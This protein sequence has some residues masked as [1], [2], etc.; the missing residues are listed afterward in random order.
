MRMKKLYLTVLTLL[1]SISSFSQVIVNEGFEAGNTDGLPPTGW[2]CDAGGWKCGFQEQDHNRIPHSGD[3]YA[4]CSYRMYKWMFKEI[5]V[6]ANSQYRVSFWHVTNGVGSFQFEVKVGN[7]PDS[8]HMTQQVFPLTQINNT[9]YQYESCTFT[10]TSAGT[11]YVGFHSC[12]DFNP[13]YLVIDDIQIEQTSEYNFAVTPLTADTSVYFGEYGHFRFNIENTGTET[14]TVTF[15]NIS[16]DY[17]NVTFTQNGNTVTNLNIPLNTTLEVVA[18]AQLPMN[19]TPNQDVTLSFDVASAHNTHSESMLFDGTAL[20]PIDEFPLMEGFDGTTFPPFGWQ[21]V[22]LVGDEVYERFTNGEWPMCQPHNGSAAMARYYSYLSQVGD[23]AILVSPK[24]QLSA[25]DNIVRFWIFR[26]YNSWQKSDKI[27]VYYSPTN[28]L[29][30]AT[31]LGTVH[32]HTE[33]EPVVPN[34]D[35]W[36]EYS[37]SFGSPEGYGFVIFEAVSDR[38]WN[39][40]I[41]DIFVNSTTVDNDPPT[42]I[43]VAGTQ[44]W[45]DTDMEITVRIYDESNVPDEMEATY[46]IDGQLNNVTFHK[47]A[48][49]NYDFV[50]TIPARENHTSGYIVFHLED[51]LGHAADSDPY[52]IHWDWQRPLLLEGFEGEQFP[53]K[54]W[55]MESANMSWFVWAR[56]GTTYYT[57]SDNYEYVVTPKQGAKQ[58]ALEWDYTDEAGMQDEALITPMMTIERPTAL[59]FET[60]CHYGFPYHDHFTVSILNTNTGIWDVVW[61]AANHSQWINQYEENVHIDLSDYQGQNIRIKWRGYNSDAS[62]LWYSW[63]IDKVKVVPTDTIGTSVN[64]IAMNDAVAYPNPFNNILT[65]KGEETIQTINI[66]NLLGIKVN[67]YAINNKEAVLDLS[68]LEVGM[69]MIEIINRNGK[70][71]KSVIKK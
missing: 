41:D 62:N 13:W 6:E 59:T 2:I 29:D 51:E 66:F 12:A 64:E 33:L 54:D 18:H 23:G 15:N 5:N 56:V 16:G 45:A 55:T 48:K 63:F 8:L 38:G 21:N 30:G 43:S 57:D 19:M 65:I 31:L 10:T 9:E 17:Q 22:C 53:P 61:D 37:F 47:S 3:W 67:E 20:K 11:Y 26:N 44:Q 70:S 28:S 14:E 39:L 42:V 60:F 52:A 27:N 58:A 36:Y 68:K 7:Q 69:Y 71:V 25:T 24:M 46:T 34:V 32:R 50:G 35:D 4:Y 1:F 40:F 49:S